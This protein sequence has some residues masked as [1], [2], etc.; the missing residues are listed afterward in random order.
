MGGKLIE[1]LSEFKSFSEFLGDEV[2]FQD[3]VSGHLIIYLNKLIKLILKNNKKT[4]SKAYR[5]FYILNL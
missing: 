2:I 1:K 5:G 4:K 3:R